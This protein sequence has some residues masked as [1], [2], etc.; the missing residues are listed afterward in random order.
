[1]TDDLTCG[2]TGGHAAQM[3]TASFAALLPANLL[4]LRRP[5]S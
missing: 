1:M 5:A 2:C 3:T 4:R